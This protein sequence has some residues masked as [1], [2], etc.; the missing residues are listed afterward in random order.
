MKKVYLCGIGFCLLMTLACNSSPDSVK[1]A[2]KANDANKDS[3]AKQRADSSVTVA[4]KQDADFLVKAA[5]GGMLEVELGK[6]AQSNGSKQGVKDFG[7]MM[8]EDHGKG[9]E[10]LKS[11]AMSKKIVLPDSMSND[12]KKERDDLMKKQGTEFD[13][14]YVSL[15]VKD[16]K[17]D[18][19]EFEKA[20][21]DG[22]D[23]E[24][25]MFAQ[26]TLP[27]LHHHLDSVQSLEKKMPRKISGPK[28]APLN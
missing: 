27:M 3:L 15:M 11:L 9:G 21:K 4:S 10:T 2:E 16:H 25:R 26:N 23:A 7:A 18:I 14:S 20:A 28:T 17:E 5:S 24:I 19:D 13:R 12:Q 22:N 8:V 6:L 1:E